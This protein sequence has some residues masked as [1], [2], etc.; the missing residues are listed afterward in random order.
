[1]LS[2]AEVHDLLTRSR[3]DDLDG[4]DLLRRLTGMLQQT[5][6]SH[7]V[8]ST[9]APLV[10][11][12]A[13]ATA[14]ALV[15]CELLSNAVEHGGGAIEVSLRRDGAFGVLA[16]RDHGPGP[17]PTPTGRGKGLAIADALAQSELAGSLR[18]RDAVPGVEASL[19]FPLL[20]RAA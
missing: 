17:A 9:L 5:L 20:S 1:V 18:F 10:L 15:Y 16:V 12:P 13:R 3:E 2:I 19:R 11:A 6:G 7:E 8:S 14:L 4:A